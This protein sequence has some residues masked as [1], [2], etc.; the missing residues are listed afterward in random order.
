MCA[1]KNL[2]SLFKKRKQL[3]QK[4]LKIFSTKL[5][6]EFNEIYII[7]L[8]SMLVDKK[9]IHIQVKNF[10]I[11]MRKKAVSFSKITFFL[12][13]LGAA[14]QQVNNVDI[15]TNNLHHLHLL[16]QVGQFP[17]GGVIWWQKNTLMR[18]HDRKL[19]KFKTIIKNVSPSLLILKKQ[20]LIKK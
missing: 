10:V 5:I 16:N 2:L 18:N 12:T 3:H 14:S 17:I 13:I 20:I 11:N 8:K 19:V 15:T 7:Q 9:H 1:I 4:I 6:L